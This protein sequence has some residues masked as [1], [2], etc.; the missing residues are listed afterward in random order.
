MCWPPASAMVASAYRCTVMDVAAELKLGRDESRR[1]GYAVILSMAALHNGARHLSIKR[2]SFRAWGPSQVQI[3]AASM[4]LQ[5]AR[6]RLSIP[7]VVPNVFPRVHLR[8]HRH[9][10]DRCARRPGRPGTLGHTR[11]ARQRTGRGSGLVIHCWMPRAHS[12][13]RTPPMRAKPTATSTVSTIPRCVH[14][15]R[16]KWR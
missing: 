4:H 6:T 2:S 14:S 3:Q 13:A 16:R 5:A 15:S 8:L 1:N 11:R 9:R 7:P 10:R 12:G